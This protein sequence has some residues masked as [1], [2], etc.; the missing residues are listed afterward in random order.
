MKNNNKL[1]IFAILIIAVVVGFTLKNRSAENKE[2]KNS[3]ISENVETQKNQETE[4]KVEVPNIVLKDQYGKEHNLENYKGKVVFINFWATWC[5][6]CVEEMPYLEKLAKAYPNDVVVLGIAG[7][8]S[9]SA[10]N[11]PDVSKE[12]IIKFLEERKV[13]YPVLFDETGEVFD[14]YGIQFFPTSYIVGADGYLASYIPGAVTESDLR[15]AVE[16]AMNK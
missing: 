4:T 11:N 3:N 16:K 7:P 14:E 6:Y 15:K 9:N 5:G 13:T 2:V 1:I 10:P 8:K 12:E